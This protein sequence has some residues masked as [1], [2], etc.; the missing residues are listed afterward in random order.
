[1]IIFVIAFCI[2]LFFLTFGLPIMKSVRFIRL[3]SDGTKRIKLGQAFDSIVQSNTSFSYASDITSANIVFFE[4]L[5]DFQLMY[6]DISASKP[7]PTIFYSL[8]CIDH[9]A[10]KSG[11]YT[12][13]SRRLGRSINSVVPPTMILTCETTHKEVAD[14]AE[15]ES[16]DMLIF[17]SN[18]QQQQGLK[19]V[20][21]HTIKAH[22]FTNYVVV[23][24]VLNRPY[25]IDG[26]KINLRQ[27]VL[28]TCDVASKLRFYAYDDGFVY[29]T[30]NRFDSDSID[31]K[32]QITT[33]YVSRDFY[34][35]NPL[36]IGDFAKTLTT[37]KRQIFQD[38][39]FQCLAH[40]FGSIRDDLEIYEKRF[41]AK[42][43]TI[44]GVDLFITSDLDVV[45]MEINKG[46]DLRFKDRKRDMEL[47]KEL[48]TNTLDLV[49]K[50]K[51]TNFKLLSD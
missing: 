51:V 48:I 10:S 9:L 11:L 16:C 34:E 27:Y 6:E 15:R 22:D 44:L 8:A 25:V 21:K 5:T 7:G 17:K 50:E 31:F 23:Q 30:K 40:L 43:F 37:A 18:V 35:S 33:G 42:K 19:L 45:M 32:N 46:C 26:H 12:L 29:Y 39:R 2:A 13:L 3:S 28:V 38:N 1:M 47:K 4:K 36:T 49:I 41:P 24:K 20:P 14:F